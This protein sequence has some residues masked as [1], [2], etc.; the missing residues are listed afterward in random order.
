MNDGVEVVAA[1]AVA[2]ANAILQGTTQPH[3][4]ARALWLMQTELHELADALLVFVGLASE[5]EDD[6]EHRPE[7]EHDILVEAERLR[8][9]FG[10]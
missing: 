5:W 1:R 8:A 10:K 6:Q 2:H 4:G 9:R 7:L 3:E